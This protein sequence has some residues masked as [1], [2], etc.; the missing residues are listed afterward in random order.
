MRY[1]NSILITS[2]VRIR[3]LFSS[4]RI[5][6]LTM[7]P[8]PFFLVSSVVFANYPLYFYWGLSSPNFFPLGAPPKGGFNDLASLPAIYKLWEWV[9]PQIEWWSDPIAFPLPPCSQGL[10]DKHLESQFF[11]S[12]TR[13]SSLKLRRCWWVPFKQ[14]PEDLNHISSEI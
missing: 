11:F 13:M 5:I 3:F 8:V 14:I 1:Y 7:P 9:S 10:I 4:W 2:L 12:E 6:W